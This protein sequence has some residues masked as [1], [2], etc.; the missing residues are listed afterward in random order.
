MTWDELSTVA[1]NG[2][3]PIPK[4]TDLLEAWPDARFNIDCKERSRLPTRSPTC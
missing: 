3:E 4:L 2:R 1:V